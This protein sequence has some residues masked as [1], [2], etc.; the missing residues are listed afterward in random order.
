MGVR[1]EVGVRSGKVARRVRREAR[2]RVQYRQQ[3]VLAGGG[4]ACRSTWASGGG[5]SGGPR[6]RAPLLRKRLSPGC[7]MIMVAASTPCCAWFA[8][9]RWSSA[10][11]RPAR[12]EGVSDRQDAKQTSATTNRC[13]AGVLTRAR[14]GGRALRGQARTGR[15]L[16]RTPSSS[17]SARI[18]TPVRRYAQVK[19]QTVCPLKASLP[20]A[21][22][23]CVAPAHTRARWHACSAPVCR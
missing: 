11:R 13:R 7:R 15:S 22:V 6:R 4:G 10:Q 3:R 14:V 8:L 5:E 16:Q 19:A 20:C 1:A 17:Q 2:A 9:L 23:P 21:C 12:G 18:Q